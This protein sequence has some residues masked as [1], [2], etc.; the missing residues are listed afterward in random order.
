MSFFYA[1]FCVVFFI[2]IPVE[3]INHTMVDYIYCTGF[4]CNEIEGRCLF[5]IFSKKRKLL[6]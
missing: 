5:N 2:G 6:K 4:S 1:S 3:V